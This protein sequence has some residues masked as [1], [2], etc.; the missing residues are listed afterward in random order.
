[1]L[2]NLLH[3]DNYLLK[4]TGLL[5]IGIL[6]HLMVMT[7]IHEYGHLT[8]AKIGGV[9]IIDVQYWH[10][11][12]A[13]AHTTIEG[14]FA[15]PV[16]SYLYHLGGQFFYLVTLLPFLLYF[17]FINKKSVFKYVINVLLIIS[18]WDVKSD[19]LEIGQ[20]TKSNI[21]TGKLMC[22]FMILISINLFYKL[23]LDAFQE[24]SNQDSS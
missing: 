3:V 9:E 14:E 17:S 23:L 15:S 24:M 16:T 19:C 4:L 13:N 12:N 5:L 22:I 18:F 2:K 20:T 7:P 1:M 8:F 11:W 10:T 21:L 6:I